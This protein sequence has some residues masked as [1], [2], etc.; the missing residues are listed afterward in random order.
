MRLK[1][2][3]RDGLVVQLLTVLFLRLLS[4]CHGWIHPKVP[5]RENSVLPKR[6]KRQ[7]SFF[8]NHSISRVTLLKQSAETADDG[9]LDFDC[10]MEMDCVIFSRNNAK[11]KELAV[12]E[13]DMLQPI[14]AWTMEEAF[15]DY[16]EFVVDEE[17]RGTISLDDNI[18]IYSLIP[19]DS[20]S[21]GSRQVG[22]GK[23]PGNPHGEES[24][25]L[26]YIRKG[27][28]EGIEVNVKPELEI[29]W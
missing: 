19:E 21:Y 14:S 9:F 24:E 1:R 17:D 28:L 4:C 13:E 20:L 5:S 26:Y 25:L 2:A 29:T 6:D 12:L 15:D 27:S 8:P 22:G 16:V 18:Q 3:T 23:G 10:L 7:A 11:T